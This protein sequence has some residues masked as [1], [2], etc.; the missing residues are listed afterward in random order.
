MWTLRAQV[1]TV[2]RVAGPLTHK[3]WMTSCWEVLLA[4]SHARGQRCCAKKFGRWIVHQ[5]APKLADTLMVILMNATCANSVSNGGNFY[6]QHHQLSLGEREIPTRDN[7]LMLEDPQTQKKVK[8]TSC[9]RW[10]TIA[11]RHCLEQCNDLGELRV[12]IL[13]EISETCNTQ[14]TCNHFLFYVVVSLHPWKNVKCHVCVTN[15]HGICRPHC[16]HR[17]CWS[18][19]LCTRL[20]CDLSVSS[21]KKRSMELRR[22]S[23]IDRQQ[24]QCKSRWMAKQM[25][26]KSRW[27]A[28]K[29]S[30]D[31]S[32]NAFWNHWN[33]RIGAHRHILRILQRQYC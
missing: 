4:V 32:A 27:M 17:T 25:Q 6:H 33:T 9:S 21:C 18:I 28:V 14:V 8:R 3:A 31:W 12:C 20:F 11:K 13:A 29:C 15:I 10:G 5:S 30:G 7:V 1:S 16:T 26:C 22:A 23:N 19:E 2:G 24:M